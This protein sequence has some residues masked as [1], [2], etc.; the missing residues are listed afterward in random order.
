MN[1]TQLS[2]VVVDLRLREKN[3]NKRIFSFLSCSITSFEILRS[4]V[5]QFTIKRII[6]SQTNVYKRYVFQWTTYLIHLHAH[7]EHQLLSISFSL[8]LVD[9]KK[10]QSKSKW[11]H[12]TLFHILITDLRLCIRIN[13]IFI[14]N[15]IQL[16]EKKTRTNPC[17]I[18]EVTSLI[19]KVFNTFLSNYQLTNQ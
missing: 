4:F 14:L 15:Q 11:L 18:N 19:R 16:W 17:Q 13:F 8:I 7:D 6:S 5:R 2:I 3:K 12:L 1:S 9:R 10:K